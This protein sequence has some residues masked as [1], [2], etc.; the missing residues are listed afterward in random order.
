MSRTVHRMDTKNNEDMDQ[1]IINI[2]KNDIREEVTHDHI[3]RTH[4]LRKQ[5]LDNNVPWPIT[6]KFARTVD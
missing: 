2:I 1:R 5:K 6:V 3:D 4:Y